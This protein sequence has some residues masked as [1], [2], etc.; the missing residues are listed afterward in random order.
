M[1]G[2]AILATGVVMYAAFVAVAAALHFGGRL[3]DAIDFRLTNG[4]WPPAVRR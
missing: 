3:L 4:R 1:N 2:L